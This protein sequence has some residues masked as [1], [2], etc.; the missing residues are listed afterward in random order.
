MIQ[1]LVIR[2]DCS[3]VH[4]SDLASSYN[5]DYAIMT[6]TAPV[7]MGIEFDPILS[8]NKTIAL[9][10]CNYLA[11]S[12]VVMVFH[13]AW[14]HESG[15]ERG[16]TVISDLPLK[17]IYYPTELNKRGEQRVHFWSGGR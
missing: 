8:Q 14:W 4:C 15:G 11:S 9:R 16:G 10:A 17:T 3:G 6:P 13:T 12:K 5:A 1:F 2:V 7:T